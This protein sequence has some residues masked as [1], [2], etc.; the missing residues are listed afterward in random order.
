MN[1]IIKL[2]KKLKALADQGYGG[3]KTNAQEMLASLMKKHNLQ[4]KDIEEPVRKDRSFKCKRIQKV[5]FAQIV[6]HI[7]G[8]GQKVFQNKTHTLVSTKCSYAEYLEIEATFDFFWNSYQE[9]LKIFYQAFVYRNNLIPFDAK[10]SEEPMGLEESEK[11]INM[12]RSID[13]KT[14]RKQIT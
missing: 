13:K 2:A 11:L 9:E 4:I 1:P 12:M 7:M 3:E 10:E 6:S 5:M 14:L 8:V